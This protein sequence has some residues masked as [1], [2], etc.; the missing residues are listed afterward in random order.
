MTQK[1]PPP[2]ASQGG[3]A[4]HVK[5]SNMP[6]TS[7]TALRKEPPFQPPK[8]IGQGPP[9]DGVCP[10]GSGMRSALADPGSADDPPLS[11]QQCRSRSSPSPRPPFPPR[12]PSGPF[13]AWRAFVARRDSPAR[14]R[15]LNRDGQEGYGLFSGVHI[16]GGPEAGVTPG[17]PERAASPEKEGYVLLFFCLGRQNLEW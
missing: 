14:L 5:I 10:A 15:D 8:S 2:V 3:R 9:A 1:A 6:P 17:L 4:W 11:R 16:R 7:G 13:P 12:A